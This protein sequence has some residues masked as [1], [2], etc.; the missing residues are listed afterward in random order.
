[1]QIRSFF[2]S[3]FSHIR[4]EYGEIFGHF[5]RSDQCTYLAV[6]SNKIFVRILFAFKSWYIILTE[7]PFYYFIVY[8]FMK[9]SVHDMDL[10]CIYYLLQ[11]V[12]LPQKLLSLL[13]FSWGRQY[14]MLL[15]LFLFFWYCLFCEYL[16]R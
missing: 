3:V 9:S 14:I 15:L 11:Y 5:S 12:I 7:W 8:N 6:P 2:W 16:W 10:E 1:M 4:T 13:Y